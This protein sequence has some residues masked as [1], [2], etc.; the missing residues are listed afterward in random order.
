MDSTGAL[1][2]LRELYCCGFHWRGA[3]VL[4]WNPQYAL[5]WIPQYVLLWIPQYALL[6]IPLAR[7]WTGSAP[8]RKEGYHL[9]D[10]HSR[11]LC[12]LRLESTI[13]HHNGKLLTTAPGS[14]FPRTRAPTTYDYGALDFPLPRIQP[15]GPPVLGNTLSST[16]PLLAW[17]TRSIP[18]IFQVDG[19]MFLG[20]DSTEPPVR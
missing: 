4:L 7:Y 3:A 9:H 17:A 6:W 1:R 10:L 13:I 14:V 5:L 15:T 20:F 18:S 19:G 2:S 12:T 8:R 16:P 11:P